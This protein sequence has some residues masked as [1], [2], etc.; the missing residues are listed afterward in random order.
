MEP[1]GQKNLTEIL[2]IGDLFM[3]KN[4]MLWA[5]NKLEKMDLLPQQALGIAIRFRVRIWLDK[6]IKDVLL[7]PTS[8]LSLEF[9]QEMNPLQ[10][11]YITY[12]IMKAREALLAERHHVAATPLFIPVNDP[13]R[14]YCEADRHKKCVQAMQTGW[15]RYVAPRILDPNSPLNLLDPLICHTFLRSLSFNGVNPVCFN[16][17]CTRVEKYCTLTAVSAEIAEVTISGIAH[18]IGG[19][20]VLE[21]DLYDDDPVMDI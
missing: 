18:Y 16:E 20:Y 9:I 21:K 2:L 6:C 8:Q 13:D 19:N 17:L 10:D 12:S 14:M 7:T 3:S 4:L 15:V 1:E 5:L 11:P